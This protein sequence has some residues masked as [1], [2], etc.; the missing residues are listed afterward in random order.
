MLSYEEFKEEI[1][2]E[3]LDYLPRKYS[4]CDVNFE[5]VMKNNG[6]INDGLVIRCKDNN[7]SP[8]IYVRSFYD[9]YA[10]G[11]PIEN[12][13]QQIAEV[14]VHADMRNNI[15]IAKV[16]DWNFVK[17]QVYFSLINRE[18]NNEYLSDRPYRDFLDLAIIYY[19]DISEL[20]LG[21]PCDTGRMNLVITNDILESFRIS[22]DELYECAKNNMY[23]LT[24]FCQYIHDLMIDNIANRL[25]SGCLGDEEARSIASQVFTGRNFDVM[26]L[27]NEHKCRGSGMIL[28]SDVMKDI[29]DKFDS[30]F[31]IIPSSIHEVLLVSTNSPI[32]KTD[33]F[34][35]VHEVNYQTVS[36]EEFLSNNLYFY[37]SDEET[38]FLV[39]D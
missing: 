5:Q 23:S 26:L 16:L 11:V 22:E 28:N 33:I 25:D 38:T 8:T 29:A 4:D 24:P 13:L 20:G 30:D 37:D 15:D 14:R 6:M 27:T 21:I 9:D 3:I 32:S 18:R 39:M 12:I 2:E 17:N 10:S 1:L 7:I 31:Y 19:I 34:Q 36:D 35:M